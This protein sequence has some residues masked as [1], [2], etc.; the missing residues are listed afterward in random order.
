MNR[1]FLAL[2]LCSTW[3]VGAKAPARPAK[4]G[5]CVACHGEDGRS[6]VLGTPH[7]AGQDESYLA[8]ALA[9][10][11]AGSRNAAPMNSIAGTLNP[12]DIAALAAWYAGQPGFPTP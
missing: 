7:L 2:L 4:L 11:R 9:A 10:Y 5:Q 12:S 8:R 6:R 3:P 1:L